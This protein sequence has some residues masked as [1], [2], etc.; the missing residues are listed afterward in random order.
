MYTWLENAPE[1]SALSGRLDD[2]K[3]LFTDL[4][5]LKIRVSASSS[6]CASTAE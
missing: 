3:T 5:S 1:L 4:M 2:A 6:V